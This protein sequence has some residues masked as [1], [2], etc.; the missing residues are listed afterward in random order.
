LEAAYEYLEVSAPI[1]IS[2]QN[3]HYTFLKVCD[4]LARYWELPLDDCWKLIDGVYNGRLVAAGQETWTE[5]E[6]LHKLRTVIKKGFSIPKRDEDRWAGQLENLEKR[7]MEKDVVRIGGAQESPSGSGSGSGDEGGAEKNYTVRMGD[8]RNDKLRAVSVGEA[9]NALLAHEDWLGVWRVNELD[10]KIVA[11][12]PPIALKSENGTGLDAD[13]VPI[14][15]WFEVRLGAKIGKE[16]LLDLVPAVARQRVYN[17][18]KEELDALGPYQEGSGSMFDGLAKI[19]FGDDRPIAD[20]FLKKFFIGAVR[21]AINPGVKMDTAL[22]LSGGQGVGKTSFAQILGGKFYASHFTQD[23]NGKDAVAVLRGSWIVELEELTQ[24]IRTEESTVKAFLTRN[25]DKFRPA[26]AREEVIFPR[27]CAFIGSTNEGDFLRDATGNRRFWCIN[28]KQQIPLNTFRQMRAGLLSEAYHWAKKS[29]E[30][31]PH[32]LSQEDSEE[33]ERLNKEF[34]YIDPWREIVVDY[35][36]SKKREFVKF[37]DVFQAIKGMD[38]NFAG[39]GPREAKRLS[40][41]LRQIG[42]SYKHT[43]NGRLWMVP[44][45]LL[46]SNP[47]RPV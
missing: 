45:E 16:A 11:V 31:A 42:C 34:E 22:I 33:L 38:S 14:Q 46:K 32:H 18:I 19:L 21:R 15:L 41:V 29:E 47:L 23:L 3:G 40:N 28:V 36:Q 27:S 37:A 39:F 25:Y 24:M 26:Y 8:M 20:V 4:R 9:L 1:S 43:A 35:L 44:K 5:K 13:I 12:N 2:G 10:G 7:L 17:P 30:E 6:T